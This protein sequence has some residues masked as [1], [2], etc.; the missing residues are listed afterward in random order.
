MEMQINSIDL[1]F[2]TL[3]NLSDIGFR[4]KPSPNILEIA[5]QEKGGVP[6]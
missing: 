6:W 4:I 3:D 1:S 5:W 2:L